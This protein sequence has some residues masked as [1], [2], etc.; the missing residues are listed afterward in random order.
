[1]PAD[2]PPVITPPALYASGPVG[3]QVIDR[4]MTWDEVMQQ[5]TQQAITRGVTPSPNGYIGCSIRGATYCWVIRIDDERVR[6]HE[7]AHCRGWPAD[8]PGG[9]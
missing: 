6:Q 2:L 3:R 5:C 4:V 7:L 9:R 8:H 1:V